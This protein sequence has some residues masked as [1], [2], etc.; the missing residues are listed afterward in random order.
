MEILS[1][2]IN[3]ASLNSGNGFMFFVIVVVAIVTIGKIITSFF[4]M[5]SS[6]FTK[7]PMASSSNADEE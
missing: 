6:I 7:K 5:I 4:E 3:W 2:L 1:M